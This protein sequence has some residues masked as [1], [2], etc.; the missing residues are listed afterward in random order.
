MKPFSTVVTFLLSF[1]ICAGISFVNWQATPAWAWEN[2]THKEFAKRAAKYVSQEGLNA[3]LTTDYALTNGVDQILNV[4]WGDKPRSVMGWIIE[5]ADSEDAPDC[6][7]FAHWHDPLMP[8]GN[9]GFQPYLA[10]PVFRGPSARKWGFGLDARKQSEKDGF[11][12][13]SFP[14]FGCNQNLDNMSWNDARS[15]FE[16]ALTEPLQSDREE[17]FARMF[18]AIGHVMHLIQDNANPAHARN[19]NHLDVL[20][21]LNL[22]LTGYGLSGFPDPDNFHKYVQLHKVAEISD[23][24]HDKIKSYTQKAETLLGTKSAGGSMPPPG[25]LIDSD[26][27]TGANP[28]VTTSGVTGTAE[29][30][31]A[32]FF[33]DDT[34]PDVLAGRT[35]PHPQFGE[36]SGGFPLYWSLQRGTHLNL[37]HALKNDIG[38][39]ILTIA[40]PQ[41]C[42][43]LQALGQSCAF[44]LDDA[45]FDDYFKELG[46]RAVAYSAALL[47]YFFRGKIEARINPGF[48]LP[49]HPDWQLSEPITVTVTNQSGVPM[50]PGELS[51][52]YERRTDGMRTLVHSQKIM[53]EV[54]NGDEI[55]LNT[56]YHHL[57]ARDR[58]PVV[59]RGEL[60]SAGAKELA[61]VIGTRVRAEYWNCVNK[62]EGNEGICPCAEA[63]RLL[64]LVPRIEQDKQCEGS[65]DHRFYWNIGRSALPN[66]QHLLGWFSLRPD[67][68]TF[69][70]QLQLFECNAN[71]SN[72]IGAG[73]CRKGL[74]RADLEACALFMTEPAEA[75]ACFLERP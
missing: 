50:G 33:T 36:L 62:V 48:Y 44:R 19:D 61:A 6:R 60:G 17:A 22:D 46:P 68:Q 45:I 5:G 15:D 24:N 54:A 28:E 65:I 64:D 7:V 18:K 9:E 38:S 52:Y 16:K 20:G 37:Q 70:S 13:E 43:G 56:F 1:S 32:N 55:T 42:L 4:K 73:T 35:Y 49:A 66:D 63:L 40:Y 25:N 69:G 47:Q 59:F 3:R 21:A 26:Q 31:N 41:Y 74:S 27:Y 2:G 12:P 57:D 39:A 71:F 67:P 10:N 23:L 51:V 53:E 58:L 11:V 14:A 8:I 29:F 30:A 75:T 72:D 34:T